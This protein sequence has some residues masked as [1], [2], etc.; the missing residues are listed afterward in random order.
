LDTSSPRATLS[1]FLKTFDEAIHFYRNV[2][3][4]EPGRLNHRRFRSILY[5]AIRALDLSEVSAAARKQ[6]GI[7]SIGLLYDIL[8]KIELPPEKTI[9]DAEAFA[10]DSAEH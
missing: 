8:S 6:E 7:D 9:P 10:A 4:D 2:Y 1:N 5:K 3:R